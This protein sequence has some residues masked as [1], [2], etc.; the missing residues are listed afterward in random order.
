MNALKLRL[1]IAILTIFAL[2]TIVPAGTALAGDTSYT[3]TVKNNAGEDRYVDI[4]KYN[5]LTRTYYSSPS[6]KKE[7]VDESASKSI[8][9]NC[10]GS[11]VKCKFVSYQKERY[12]KTQ[13]IWC[14]GYA[15]RYNEKGSKT[16]ITGIGSSTTVKLNSDSISVSY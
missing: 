3:F 11:Q 5:T 6:V 7:L 16:N 9:P 2:C 1:S 8:T 4:Y 15:E 13:F 12:C 10:G 14:W